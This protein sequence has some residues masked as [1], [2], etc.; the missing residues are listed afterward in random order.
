MGYYLQLKIFTFSKSIVAGHDRVAK[1]CVGEGRVYV[2]GLLLP[3]F[4]L[5]M[6][7]KSIPIET[8]FPFVEER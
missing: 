3:E 1:R 4:I 8:W 2:N 5:E 7:S 6:N